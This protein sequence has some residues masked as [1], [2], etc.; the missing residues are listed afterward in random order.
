MFPNKRPTFKYTFEYVRE[1]AT[2]TNTFTSS[3]PQDAAIRHLQ[4]TWGT[5]KWTG[6]I[7]RDFKIVSI[8]AA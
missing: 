5:C 2:Y 1:D 3:L 4:G 8:V 7:D 6:V